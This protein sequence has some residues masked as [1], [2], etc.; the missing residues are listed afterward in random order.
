MPP[1]MVANIDTASQQL[2]H[3][4]ADYRDRMI[5]VTKGSKVNLWKAVYGCRRRSR[6][7]GSA[8]KGMPC[9]LEFVSEGGGQ[10]NPDQISNGGAQP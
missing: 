5:M 2:L 4:H 10:L 8:G 3:V 9:R 7:S 1:A 6:Q